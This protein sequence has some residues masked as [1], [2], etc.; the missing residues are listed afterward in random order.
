MMARARSLTAALALALLLSGCV[1]AV[2]PLAAAGAIARKKAKSAKRSPEPVSETTAAAKPATAA[3]QA[4]KPDNPS[5]ETLIDGA[6]GPFIRFALTQTNLRQT[7]YAV[8]SVALASPVVLEKPAFMACGDMPPAIIIDLDVSEA[9]SGEDAALGLPKAMELDIKGLAAG[10]ER[11]RGAGISVIWMSERSVEEQDGLLEALKASGL[12]SGD[13]DT[14]YLSGSGD[15]RKQTRR[16]EAASKSCIIAMAG[17]RK[18]DFDELFDYLRQPEA[19]FRLDP[20]IDAGWFL[21]PA[22][23]PPATLA[24]KSDEE[25]NALDPR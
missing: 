14:L 6:Y 22:P 25:T 18:A 3:A 10:L 4:P 15:Y 23:L 17:D 7:G 20:L 19:A 5:Q 12:V 1:A 13:G 2:I 8:N 9:G 16:I 21:T 24:A 11:L